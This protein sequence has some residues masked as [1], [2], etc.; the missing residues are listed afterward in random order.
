LRFDG[1]KIVSKAEGA[2]KSKLKVI[3]DVLR[4]IVRCKH[5]GSEVLEVSYSDLKSD[6]LENVLETW[7]EKGL[8]KPTPIG[9]VISEKVFCTK[10][11]LHGIAIMEVALTKDTLKK[12]ERLRTHGELHKTHGGLIRIDAV[13]EGARFKDYAIECVCNNLLLSENFARAL[14]SLSLTVERFLE[15]ESEIP[16]SIEIQ[17]KISCPQCGNIIDLRASFRVEIPTIPHELAR[18]I[19]EWDARSRQIYA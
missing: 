6:L 16:K 10:C 17:N 5:C 1:C 13:V 3:N 14:N 11:R 9:K 4:H 15:G 8:K 2:F 19:R 7:N 18:A 12:M